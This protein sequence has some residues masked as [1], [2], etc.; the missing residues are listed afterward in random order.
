MLRYIMETK[1]REERE[2]L[3]KMC[4]GTDLGGGVNWVVE[5]RLQNYRGW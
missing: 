2:R 1:E 5:D 3:D 4:I